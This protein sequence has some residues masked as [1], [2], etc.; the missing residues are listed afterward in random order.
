MAEKGRKNLAA[1][2]QKAAVE[3]LGRRKAIVLMPRRSTCGIFTCWWFDW[4]RGQRPFRFIDVPDLLCEDKWFLY[5]C[6]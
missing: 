6:W 5:H 2:T 4:Q 3:R 1:A